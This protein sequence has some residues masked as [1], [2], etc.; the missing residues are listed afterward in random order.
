MKNIVWTRHAQ[1]KLRQH[2]LSESRVRRTLHSPDRIEKG[3]AEGTVTM[4]KKE[5]A[6]KK[7]YEIWVMIIDKDSLRRIISAWKYPVTT[8]P[9]EPL[10]EAILAEM[11]IAIQKLQHNIVNN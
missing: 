8:R 6:I 10:P 7:E 9:G 11:D 1:Y 3:I 5:R 2:A 4:M